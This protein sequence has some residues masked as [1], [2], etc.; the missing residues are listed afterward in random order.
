MSN[1]PIQYPETMDVAD[2]D[3]EYFVTGSGV[4]CNNQIVHLPA[5]D[6]TRDDPVT[7]CNRMDSDTRKFAKEPGVY[8]RGFRNVCKKCLR[9]EKLETDK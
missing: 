6:S 8:R 9:H 7:R 5:P 3:A 1:A 2:H 4:G